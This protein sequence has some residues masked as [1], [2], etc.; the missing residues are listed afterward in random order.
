MSAKRRT[1]D[2]ISPDSE[3]LAR[4]LIE[5]LD[6]VEIQQIV[7]EYHHPELKVERETRAKRQE[8]L[9]TFVNSLPD[10]PHGYKLPTG[11]EK[12]WDLLVA[13]HESDIREQW[14]SDG[15]KPEHIE[16]WVKRGWITA[17]LERRQLVS[18]TTKPEDNQ[19]PIPVVLENRQGKWESTS[20]LGLIVKLHPF[21]RA[22]C[23]QLPEMSVRE[24]VMDALRRAADCGNEGD[25]HGTML[26]QAANYL[27]LWLYDQDPDDSDDLGWLH[28]AKSS[29]Q[30]WNILNSAIGFGR[31]LAAHELFGD[32]TVEARIQRSLVLSSGRRATEWRRSI[33][34]LLD[35]F[36]SANGHEA[37]ASELLEWIGGKRPDTSDSDSLIFPNEY[38]EQFR[39]ITWFRWNETVKSAKKKRK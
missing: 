11:F 9:Q 6:P 15:H 20:Y 5:I 32:G 8:E 25:Y 7:D 23:S 24:E 16:S 13:A 39:G 12:M 10:I 26:A 1:P 35:S 21:V 36:R 17:D 4:M 27:D 18:H 34:E 14:V 33:D 37:T 19:H 2:N 3:E 29:D 30:F 31:C 38:S 28:S 22:I